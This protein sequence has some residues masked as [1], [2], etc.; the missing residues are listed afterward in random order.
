MTA[1][2]K[3]TVAG[4]ALLGA[5][6]AG[7]THA[8]AD[9]VEPSPPPI[10]T[11]AA[12]G[13]SD[14]AVIA[15]ADPA[16]LPAPAPVHQPS[17]PEIPNPTYGSGQSGSGVLGT[18]ADL[19]HQ[20]RDPYYGSD[21][22]T[23]PGSGVPAGAGPAPQLPP[24]FVSLNAP[25]SEAPAKAVGP[26]SGGPALPPGYYSLDGPPPPGYQYASPTMPT[27]PTP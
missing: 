19:W 6:L 2:L 20:V 13:D 27:V 11:D 24:G 12:A 23:G 26:T 5:A 1:G 14:Q 8:A 21:D 4:L 22:V 10:P 16:G 7:A 17:V 18:I 9:P 25:G 15:A 3:F